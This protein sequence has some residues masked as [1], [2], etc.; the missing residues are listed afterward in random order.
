MTQGL[1]FD[2][3]TITRPSEQTIA[4]MLP[5]LKEQWGIPSVPHFFGQRL[6]PAAE[7][8]LKG[9]YALI[10]AKESDE[11]IFTS[12]SAEG[13]NH[14]VMS[15]YFDVTVHTGKNQFITS[16][17]EEAPALMAIGRLEQLSCIGKM[18]PVDTSGCITAKAI[19]E[20]MT[21][22][23]A[24]VSIG[25]ANGLTGV[26]NPIEE[27]AEVCK[28]RGVLLHVDASH[29]LG[30][31]FFD[32]EEVPAQFLTF[33]G[34]S[35]HAPAGTAGLFIRGDVKC[36]P[37]I[38]GG[39]EQGGHRAGSYSMAGL[40]ALGQAAR[41]AIDARELLCTEVSRLRRK[42]EEGILS[43]IPETLVF[44]KD[45]QRVPNCTAIGFPGVS[46]EALLYLLN[47]KGVYASIGGG[48]FQQLGLIL[49][50]SGID[51]VLAHTAVSFSLSRETTED[52]IDRAVSI[53][54]DCVLHL[55]K[56]SYQI[57]KE[58]AL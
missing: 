2:N 27:I 45:R 53:I 38:L 8:A 44:F 47:R 34:S 57:M 18:A 11:V 13:V 4:R 42:F 31:M 14:V 17:I 19:V 9:I 21:P 7:E 32:W 56:I 55:R 5:F 30:K 49:S 12:S 50:A 23:T 39:T 24:L 10:G 48:A 43:S 40:A 29:V 16:A 36:S 35:F 3:N 46:N 58:G 26:I 37:F 33:N 15:T 1:Y 25:W 54:A 51:P 6:L 41:E 22:R 28:E 20:E 52:E